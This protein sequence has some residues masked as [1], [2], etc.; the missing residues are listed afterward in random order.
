MCKESM[1]SDAAARGAAFH[2]IIITRC[3]AVPYRATLRCCRKHPV[4]IGLYN[5]DLRR[6]LVPRGPDG[7]LAARG[8]GGGCAS[9]VT[10]RLGGVWLRL[11]AVLACNY[12]C[13]QSRQCAGSCAGVHL[14]YT[15]LPAE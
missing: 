3:N 13:T 9:A 6:G 5:G 4:F 1:R 2:C 8:R 15:L 10:H 11:H 14:M 12:R 7:A